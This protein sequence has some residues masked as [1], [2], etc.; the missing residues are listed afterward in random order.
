VRM[1]FRQLASYL[2]FFSPQK[3]FAAGPE[4]FP[5]DEGL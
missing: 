4:R 5:L 2:C 3:K 1:N